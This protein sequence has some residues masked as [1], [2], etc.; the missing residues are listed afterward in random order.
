MTWAQMA[1]FLARALGLNDLTRTPSVDAENGE[2]TAQN[3]E[4]SAQ[5]GE[6]TAQNDEDTAQRFSD[7]EGNAHESAIAAVAAAGIML[8][9]SDDGTLFC[10]D[11]AVTRAQM[12]TFLTRALG[13]N[14]LTRVP[15]ENGE[16]TGEKGEDIPQRFSDTEGNEHESAIAAVAAAGITLGCSD[17]GTLFCPDAAVTRAQM[18]TFLTRAL[19]L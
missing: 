9:C 4:D 17:D 18:A 5:N 14:D 6:D 16:D 13:L 11:A 3:G 10:P 2:D 12:A 15:G 7:T 19:R 8:G 1:S